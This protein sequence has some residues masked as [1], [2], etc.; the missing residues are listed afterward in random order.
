VAPEPDFAR[1][2]EAWC[3]LQRRLEG[4]CSLGDTSHATGL[5]GLAWLGL[6]ESGDV[7]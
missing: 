6:V 2:L 3:A 4:Q 7:G 5:L 1:V